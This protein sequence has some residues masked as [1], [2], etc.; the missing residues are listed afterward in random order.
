MAAWSVV[1][2]LVALDVV[3][4]AIRA[5]LHD[6]PT[7]RSD[8]GLEVARQMPAFV[9]AAVVGGLAYRRTA[10]HR[11]GAALLAL[12]LSTGLVTLAE[13]YARL[14]L[15]PSTSSVPG[16]A[17][18]SWVA[19]WSFVPILVLVG[20]LLLV[21]PSGTAP[22]QGW[23][24]LGP[25]LLASGAVATLAFAVRPGR[26]DG[27]GGRI[28]N[29]AGLPASW[30]GPLAVVIAV[31]GVVLVMSILLC[32]ASLVARWRRASAV[33]R[34]QLTWVALTAAPLGL[35]VVVHLTLGQQQAIGPYTSTI[36]DV[37]FTL[38]FVSIGV[39][40]LRYRLFD[41]DVV[42][43]RALVFAVLAI[44]VTATY[45]LLVVVVGGL[46]GRQSSTGIGWSIA[47]TA[48]VAVAFA[49]VRARAVAWS[50]RLV[51]GQTQSPYDVLADVGRRLG[52]SMSPD[53][54]LPELARSAVAGVGA[55]G[56]EVS[57][58]LHDGQR[59][60]ASWP[61]GMTLEAPG[62]LEVPIEHDGDR[63]GSFVLVERPGAALHPSAARAARRSGQ[64]RRAGPQ[65][66]AA[67]FRTSGASRRGDPAGG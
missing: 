5:H 13:S 40:I 60:A 21:F 30:R 59:R 11:V 2:F 18:A 6:D 42:V 9:V 66:G 7:T 25:V 29:P 50:N 31:A 53:D 39:A 57:L 41:V 17:A 65:H 48:V 24:R 46:L 45:V 62:D 55:A 8:A 36:A 10:G 58:F 37:L 32:A 51:Y 1:A 16:G 54:V 15:L 4:L 49:P 19:S 64:K 27:G 34:Q 38:L 67:G 12:A 22:T 23:R 14:A 28:D 20:L 61:P 3:S 63:I 52:G 44:F 43:N 47:A 35:A 33:E 26:L 56:A